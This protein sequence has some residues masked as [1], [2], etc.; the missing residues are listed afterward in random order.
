MAVPTLS[1]EIVD[2]VTSLDPEQ[3]RQ[4]LGYVRSLKRPGGA[5]G[6][7]LLRFAGTIDRQDLQQMSNAIDSCSSMTTCNFR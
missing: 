4:V 3:Q 5:E 1:R 2:E 6:K 7:T